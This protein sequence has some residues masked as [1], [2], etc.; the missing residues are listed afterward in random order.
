MS[1]DGNERRKNKRYA[2]PDVTVRFGKGGT[3]SFLA[4]FSAPCLLTTLS[5]TG[6]GFMAEQSFAPGETL[7]LKVEAPSLAKAWTCRAQ[8]VW[9]QPAASEQ[10]WRVGVRI[11]RLSDADAVIL[12]HLL[13]KSILEKSE[14]STSLFLKKVKRL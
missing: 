11:T 13:D 10:A 4:P 6:L 7:R 1:W 9:V 12:R 14:I 3:F 8:V 5:E 2:I